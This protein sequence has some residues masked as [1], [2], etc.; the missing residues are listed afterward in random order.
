MLNQLTIIQALKGL[1]EKKFSSQELVKDCLKNID[2]VDKKIGAFITVSRSKSLEKAKKVDNL[3]KTNPS[4]FKEKPL[5]G[6]PMALKDIYSTKGIKTTAG[7]KVLADYI[8][9]YDATV[10]KRLKKAGAIIIGK[11]NLDAWA[12][13]S[14]GENSDFFPT[15]NPWNLKKVPGGSS[16]G[17]AAALSSSQC[18]MS[19]GTD[20]GGSIRQPASFCNLVGLKPTYGRVSRYG[21]ISMASSLD[22]IGHFTK[23]VADSAF[24]L[25]ITAGQD[26]LDATTPNVT[27]PNYSN[28]LTKPNKELKIGLPKEYFSEGVDS[29][30][31]KT[32]EIA[33]GLLEAQGHEIINVSLKTTKYACPA[34]YIIQPAEL[35]SNLARFDGIRYGN[36][37]SF[38]GDEAKRRIMLGTYTLSSGYYEAYY[39]KAMKLR[40][41]IISDFKKVFKEVDL[42]LAP[43]SP[44]PPFN[45][46]EKVNDPLKMYLSDVLTISVNLAGLPAMS[47]PCGFTNDNLP[48]GMQFIALQFKEEVLFNVGHQYQQLTDWHKKRPNI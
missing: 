21:I 27:V 5:L 41:L 2:R 20:T 15:H 31:R 24:V 22:S 33:A 10:V 46:G 9:P 17:S 4:I 44:F 23:T 3:I 14:S 45:L 30:M 1:Q 26:S 32:V 39:L 7:S 19:M 38:F 47:L 18:L 35:S 43:V 16:S 34:Y 36:S 11:T 48:I 12:H 13:G 25:Q 40:S 6:I 29:Q 28:K 8:P 37:R 42:L